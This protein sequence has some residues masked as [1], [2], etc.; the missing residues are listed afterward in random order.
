MEI[1]NYIFFFLKWVGLFQKVLNRLGLIEIFHN[2]TW[3]KKIYD[4]A[5][6]RSRVNK[7][8]LSQSVAIDDCGN[9]IL[10]WQNQNLNEIDSHLRWNDASWKHI[11][12]KQCSISKGFDKKKKVRDLGQSFRG[13]TPLL[14][15]LS[16]DLDN[17]PK[18][19]HR[20]NK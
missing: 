10:R 17:G 15:V 9:M 6:R 1:F 4:Q 12:E 7:F 19:D 16:R 11:S 18:F 8:K 5:H 20:P 2:R 13:F 14:I 3:Q